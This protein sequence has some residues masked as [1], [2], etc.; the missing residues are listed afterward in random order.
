MATVER[1]P[2]S[3]HQTIKREVDSPTLISGWLRSA[4]VFV[5]SPITFMKKTVTQITGQDKHKF[6]IYV[7][8]IDYLIAD[9]LATDEEEAW[10]IARDLDG[11]L[12]RLESS[13]FGSGEWEIQDVR[14]LDDDSDFQPVN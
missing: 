8:S 11:G 6:R 12:F 4:A 14:P 5:S 2:L 1:L 3:C 10:T 9:I 7:H 13:R